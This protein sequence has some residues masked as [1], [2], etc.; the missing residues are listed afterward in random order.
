MAIETP[1][2]PL[3]YASISDLDLLNVLTKLQAERIQVY[4]D[5]NGSLDII[6]REGQVG[7]YPA[8]CAEVTS[9]FAVISK[10]IIDVKNTILSRGDKQNI[11][12]DIAALQVGD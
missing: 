12:L 11:A 9:L 5:Y 3:E 1:A 2:I 8:L 4:S 6:I 7:K 10:S